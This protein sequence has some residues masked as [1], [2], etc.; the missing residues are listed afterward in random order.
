M[1]RSSMSADLINLSDDLSR[2]VSE[3]FEIEVYKGTHLLI[4]NIPYVNAHQK[5]GRGTFICALTLAPDNTRTGP[6]GDHT[7]YFKGETPCNINGK[8]LHQIINSS[9]HVAIVDDISADHYL[10]SKPEGTGKYEN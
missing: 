3:G 1:A 5:L 8:A 9:S 10:S 7:V 4:H 6:P 2:L